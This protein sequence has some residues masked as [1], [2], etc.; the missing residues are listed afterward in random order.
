MTA[1]IL[2]AQAGKPAGT[3][4]K[5]REDFALGVLV[6]ATAVGGPFASQQWVLTDKPVDYVTPANSAAL[7][8]SPTAPATNITPIDKEGTYLLLLLVDSG[9]GLGAN[10]GD[11]ASIDFYAGTPLNATYNLLP[12]RVLAANERGEHNVNDAI[13][14]AGNPRGW[15]QE[16]GRWFEVIKR[17]D[18]LLSSAVGFR[19]S[20][21]V[22][23]T[24]GGASIVS[25]VNVA[26]AVR[27]AIGRVT[28]TFT[29][30]LANAN[31][32]VLGSTRGVIGGSVNASAE[33]TT[34]FVVERADFGG[35]L[36]DDDFCVL[37]P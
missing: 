28:M 8:V 23:L 15:S 33:S 5:A 12:R 30:A 34:T 18:A 27:S 36:V 17:H 10:P 16:M 24:S 4:G 19:A 26:T 9:S 32:P 7:V 25:G 29:V 31:Y 21:R 35:S 14:P 6:T 11:V 3:A 13:F 2:L 37:V 20:A 22:H 1:Q